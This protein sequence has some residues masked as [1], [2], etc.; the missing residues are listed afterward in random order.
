M[1]PNNLKRLECAWLLREAA[2]SLKRYA[3]RI[4]RCCTQNPNDENEA[5]A[6]QWLTRCRERLAKFRASRA[7]YLAPKYETATQCAPRGPT[8]QDVYGRDAIDRMIS[9][10]FRELRKNSSSPPPQRNPWRAGS[11]P[12]DAIG[13]FRVLSGSLSLATVFFR[14]GEDFAR[15]VGWRSTACEAR[16]RL[17]D[18]GVK[19]SARCP[20]VT[21][22]AS[23]KLPAVQ[24]RVL[25]RALKKV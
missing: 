21:W 8:L 16:T 18:L 4:E 5:K 24:C 22:A 19:S 15:M 10:A 9:K 20:M 17:L 11:V 23:A 14:P 25:Q 12:N 7:E 6:Q 1:Q 13:T 2:W 3:D